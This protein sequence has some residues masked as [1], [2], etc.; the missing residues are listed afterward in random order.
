MASIAAQLARDRCSALGIGTNKNPVKYLNQ[1]YEELRAQC[2]AS[3]KLFEDL[4]FPPAQSSLG[5]NDLGPNSE[6]VQG[7]VWK[8]PAEIKENPQFIN[9]GANRADVRQGSLGDCWF[10]CSIASLTLNE[11]CLNRVVPVDQSFNNYAGIFHF[12]FWQYGQWV[13]VVV[14][15]RLPT[16]KGKL[17]FVKSTAACEFWSALL[18]KAYAKLNG[19]YEALKGGLPLEALEDFTG[20]VGELY[21]FENLPNNLFQIIRNALKTKSLVTC[22]TK[23]DSGSGEIV[24]KTNVVKN[25]AYSLT[26]AEEV[27]YRG[28][29]VQIVR[30]RNPW[31]FKEWNG[32]WSDTAPEWNEI[33]PEVKTR[34][35]LQCDDGETWMPLSS[36]LVEFYRV[37]IC[38]LNLDIAC[39]SEKHKWCLTGFNGKWTSGVT[40]GGC[41]GNCK[42]LM[43]FWTNP[44]YRITLE[45]PDEGKNGDNGKPCCTVLVSLM[46]KERRRKKPQGGDLLRIGYYIYKVPKIKQC[47]V[48]PQ[49]GND[50]FKK[51]KDAARLDVYKDHREVSNRFLL[52][53]GNYVIVPTTFR[54]SEEADFFL[55]VISEKNAKALEVG[56]VVEASLY[57]K[58]AGKDDNIVYVFRPGLFLQ[59]CRAPSSS[60]AA[61]AVTDRL[62]VIW[63]VARFFSQLTPLLNSTPDLDPQNG[64]EEADEEQQIE[65]F[66]VEDVRQ[67]VNKR[68]VKYT[69]YCSLFLEDVILSFH[70]ILDERSRA[71]SH[72]GEILD[73]SNFILSPDPDIKSA[74]FGPRTCREMI[75]LMDVDNTGTLSAEEYKILWMK[76]E[77]Y[78]KIFLEVDVNHSGTIDA[79]EMRNAI[80]RAGFNLN[81][82]IQEIIVQRYVSNELFI[83]FEDFIA[84]L[85]RL[86]TLFKMFNIL[87]ADKS[88]SVSLSLTEPDRSQFSL[89]FP[90]TSGRG[91]SALRGFPSDLTPLLKKFSA[92]LLTQF[93]GCAVKG[94][95]V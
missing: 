37:E 6:K 2:L 66:N 47:L 86:E 90:Q 69:L 13:D 50:F 12:K 74:G 91:R 3:G 75:N 71:R 23:S 55:R 95:Y 9:E 70:H 4:T 44:Q 30:V 49:L 21:Y 5:V 48:D 46:Q 32:A 20:G 56:N 35:N 51:N 76:L 10:L 58:I 94:D 7:L 36:F 34:L 82:R 33:D 81:T 57:E 65:E 14:D 92:R 88:G 93:S 85:I 62:S 1:D 16:K 79:Y 28:D 25:H 84:C 87:D 80:Q 8:R 11:E 83:S 67:A 63:T 15:D 29:K 73:F 40:A 52:P 53:T 61:I 89:H 39:R 54:P 64:D 78:M 22:S 45:D 41:K 17:L 24:V 26:G 18:E 43:T 42:N 59:G 68:L 77:H 19:S 38:H 27:S 72:R 31:G 60:T